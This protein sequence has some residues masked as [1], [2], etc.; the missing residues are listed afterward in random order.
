L[1][2]ERPKGREDQK[3]GESIN[4]TTCIFFFKLFSSVLQ[5][6][7]AYFFPLEK[8]AWPFSPHE[9]K[10]DTFANHRETDRIFARDHQRKMNGGI[11]VVV[12]VFVDKK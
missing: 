5:Q 7:K 1:G 2:K 9:K 3:K 11:H 8:A 12:V 10:G 4:H 6:Q